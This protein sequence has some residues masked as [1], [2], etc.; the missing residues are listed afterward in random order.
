MTSRDI[1]ALLVEA[2]AELD[3]LSAGHRPRSGNSVD[4]REAGHRRLIGAAAAAVLVVAGIGAVVA[5]RQGSSGDGA[6][7]VSPAAP[8]DPSSTPSD[9]TGDRLGVVTPLTSLPPT[10]PA[11]T[12][13]EAEN[14]LI[15][16]AD[17]N[18]CIDP[19]SPYAAAFG[20]RSNL[21]ER[22]DT[23]MILRVDPSTRR[24]AVLSFPRDLWV[25]IAGTDRNGRINSAYVEDDPTQLIYTLMLNFGVP[26]DHFIQIDFC[27]FKTII[28]AIGGVSVPFETPVRDTHTGLFVP[29]AGCFT[30]DGDHALAYV[31]SRHLQS[32]DTSGQWVEDPTSDLGRVSRQQDFIR[33]V[34][35]SVI[36]RGLTDPAV[37]QA[38]ISA[39]R[40]DVVVD[41]ELT[42]AKM[43]DL[44][45]VLRDIAPADIT[46]YQIETTGA[47]I[48]GQA[49]LLPVPDSDASQSV[50]QIF[51]GEAPLT[52]ATAVSPTPAPAGNPVGVVPP[53]AADC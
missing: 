26:V 53:A 10:T 2:G 27:A 39:V 42:I 48:S 43:L 40:D 51:R 12:A 13:V 47:T 4:H 14:Y 11:P 22:S 52:A 38:I 3:R 7:S 29:Q 5:T 21:G 20:D 36:D 46:G 19:D 16:G 31:R 35:S 34:L 17:N 33:R 24:A 28:D 50:L 44:A 49:V 23:I 9:S 41:S 37:A 1:D 30:F 15:T 6:P 25:E 8:T 45:Q 18:A 32:Y